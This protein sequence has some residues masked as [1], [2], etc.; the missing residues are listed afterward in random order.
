MNEKFVTDGSSSEMKMNTL[1]DHLNV[2]SHTGEAFYAEM[3]KP[4]IKPIPMDKEINLDPKKTIMSKTDARGIIEYAN[5]Y[6]IEISGYEEYELMGQPHNSIRHPEMPKTIF[7]ILWDS[8]KKGENI[9]AF[10]KNLAKDGRYYWVLTNFE[11]KMD[12]EGNIQSY[13]AKRK[14]APRNAIQEIEKLYYTL[15]NIENRQGMQAGVNYLNGLL[16]DKKMSF[17]EY[18]LS[19]LQVDSDTLKEYFY[20]LRIEE[21]IR[22]QQEKKK[23]VFSRMFS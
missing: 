6:F 9:H 17:N 8:L 13:Y 7:K 2:K 12:A 14:A 11:F 16:E 20:D 4:I 19:I 3:F 22:S 1:M 18:I 5:D 10:I 21:N 23:G 15:R